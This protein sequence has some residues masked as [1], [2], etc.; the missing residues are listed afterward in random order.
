LAKKGPAPVDPPPV[1]GTALKLDTDGHHV[2]SRSVA[3]ENETRLLARA[4]TLV[5]RADIDAARGV[6]ERAMA[7]GSAEAA[8]ILGETYDERILAEWNVLGTQADAGKARKLYQRAFQGGFAQAEER[9][10]SIVL[11]RDL[12][13]LGT[14]SD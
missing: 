5:E 10:G 7:E 9:L 8:F 4:R 2:G 13:I 3:G 6:L 1:N 11:H 12:H 14:T